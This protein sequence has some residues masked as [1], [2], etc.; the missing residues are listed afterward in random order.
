MP[1]NRTDGPTAG[2]RGASFHKFVW[3]IAPV[4]RVS[5]RSAKS[6]LCWINPGIDLSPRQ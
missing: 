3:K 4:N 5:R 1:F 2:P 6:V